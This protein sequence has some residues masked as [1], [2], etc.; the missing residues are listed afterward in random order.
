ML[1]IR[2]IPALLLRDRGLVKTVHFKNP[3][4]V[5]DPVNAVRIFNE[6]EVDELIFFD[7]TATIE[8]RGPNFSLISDIA[9]ECFMPLGYG[10]GIRDL[11]D[12]KE[13]FNL[14]IEKIVI[15]TRAV[16]DPTFVKTAA[17]TFGN[18]SIVVS[19]DVKR[20]LFGKYEVFTHGGAKGTGIDPVNFAKYMEEMGAGEIILTSIDRDGEMSGYDI[21]LLKKVTSILTI[22][23]VA[24]G[25]AGRIEH[26][27]DA[28]L[29]GG[30]AAVAAG[31]F[32][33][34]SG[35]HRAVLI[36]Y[37]SEKELQ[38]VFAAN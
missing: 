26:F 4:Y 12:I 23:V 16:K 17:D 10:G 14:G 38:K 5:G 33:V 15:N 24:S 1:K 13:L 3:K 9:S 25:G 11:Q 37:P 28:I 7:T 36:T 19:I 31:S 22:P 2:V 34:F 18:Q 20:T 21:E 6:K 29:K 27:V 32:F 8:N 35:K 30:A